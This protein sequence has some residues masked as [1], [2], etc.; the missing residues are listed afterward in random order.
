MIPNVA[1]VTHIVSYR[2][3]GSLSLEFEGA[4]SAVYTLWFQVKVEE[5]YDGEGRYLAA[6]ALYPSAVL[7]KR[8]Q[9][10]ESRD[11]HGYPSG[12]RQKLVWPEVV[13]LLTELEPHVS[14]TNSSYRWVHEAMLRSALSGGGC[15]YPLPSRASA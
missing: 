12:A 5:T 3:G 2:D 13:E 15:P 8:S 4:D 7:C 11:K 10:E 14:Q 1:R 6:F 9:G